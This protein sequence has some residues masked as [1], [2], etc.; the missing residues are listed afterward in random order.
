MRKLSVLLVVVL[1]GLFMGCG[2]DSAWYKNSKKKKSKRKAA[3]KEM[4]DIGYSESEA[5]K[6]YQLQ[7]SI[8]QTRHGFEPPEK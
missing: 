2:G 1:S 4:R 6:Q 7:Q 8:D 5:T 3:M